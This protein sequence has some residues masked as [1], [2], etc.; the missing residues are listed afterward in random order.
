MTPSL[1]AQSNVP[2]ETFLA[3]YRAIR[4]ATR[5]K[6]EAGSVL[7]NTKKAAKRDGIDLAT[8]K[9]LEQLAKL[10]DDERETQLRRL[11][12]YATWAN[13]PLGTQLDAFGQH[14][15]PKVKAKA[16]R[17]HELWEAGEAGLKAG[18]T[19]A[20]RDANPH[21]PGSEMHVAWDKSWLAGQGVIASELNGNG[22]AAKPE[23][24]TKTAKAT[25]A[26]PG[27]RGRVNGT[28]RASL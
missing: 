20:L 21:P 27:K 2:P 18:K 13:L 11:E 7:A 3:H 24:P 14:Q 19:G 1:G 16:A 12:Q 5:D 4:A 6:D 26:P 28:R 25:K 10:D 15:I 23:K 8:L 22:D 9:L 17:E